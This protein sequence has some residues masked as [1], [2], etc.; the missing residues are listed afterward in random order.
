VDYYD[1][2]WHVV[3]GVALTVPTFKI[4]IQARQEVKIEI[5][6][7]VAAVGRGGIT[8]MSGDRRLDVDHRYNAAVE[9]YRGDVA[10]VSNTVRCRGA[11]YE[12]KEFVELF[13][14][15]VRELMIEAAAVGV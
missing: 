12:A 13:K 9:S 14:R 7:G 15:R 1:V 5:G 2:A 8:L 3:D 10:A 6:G 11:V 4:T